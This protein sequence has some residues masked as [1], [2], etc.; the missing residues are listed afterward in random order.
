MMNIDDPRW[1]EL[2][3]GN[4]VPYDPRPAFERLRLDTD[5]DSAWQELW[6]NLESGGSVGEASYAA[7]PHLLEIVLSRP[8]RP[9][10][11]FLIAGTIELER[12]SPDNPELP[13]WLAADYS[14]AWEKIFELARAEL[15]AA[16]DPL[17]LRCLLATIA[18]AKGD[19]LRGRL[20]LD[21][22]D[23]ALEQMLGEHAL[24]EEYD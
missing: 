20:L 24:G 19:N 11:F 5:P 17:T 22:D 2:A 1:S 6:D 10:S 8:E 16:R 7:I 9:W 3:G 13:D 15:A 23:E 4:G 14:A 21:H 12:E 18:I